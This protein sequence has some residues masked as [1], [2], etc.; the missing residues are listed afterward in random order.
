MCP[1]FTG[2]YPTGWLYFEFPGSF[3][4]AGSNWFLGQEPKE[5]PWTFQ[6]TVDGQTISQ[7]CRA[8]STIPRKAVIYR[9]F[10]QR[11]PGANPKRRPRSLSISAFAPNVGFLGSQSSLAVVAGL[12]GFLLLLFFPTCQDST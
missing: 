8:A 6:T 4:P 12:L 9:T 11:T 3:F 5:N 2:N 1:A 7:S 10:A